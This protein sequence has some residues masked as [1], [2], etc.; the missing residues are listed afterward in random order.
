MYDRAKCIQCKY[1]AKLNEQDWCCVYILM[2]QERRGC[3][4]EGDCEK[5]EKLERRR[6]PKM[7]IVK[8]FI[9]WDE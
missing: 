9:Y 4:G 3:Y 7:D 2:K 6:K 1:S 8:G 5:F